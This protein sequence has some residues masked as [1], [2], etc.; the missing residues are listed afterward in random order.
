M[1]LQA[2]SAGN[3]SSYV[4]HDDTDDLAVMS[5]ITATS[6]ATA[7]QDATFVEAPGLANASCVSFESINRPG[8]YLRH[9]AFVLHLQPND[10]SSTFAHDATFCPKA[11]NGGQ[12]VSFQSVNFTTK[13][14]RA[15]QGGVY[16]AGNGGTNPWDATTNWAQD[17]SWLVADPLASAP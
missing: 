3:T 12:G 10:G 14:I 1:S 2:T 11:G 16:V 13:Y 4:R 5:T 7:K 9:Y 8:S 6:S 15:Y 17:T